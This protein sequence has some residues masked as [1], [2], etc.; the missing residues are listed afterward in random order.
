[1]AW[2]RTVAGRL[3]SDFRYSAGIVYNN[4]PWP[5]PT[6]EQQ[7]HVEEKAR[8]VLAA[9]EPH[10]PPRGMSTLADLYDPLIMPAALVRAHVE[11][12][13]EVEKCYR[14]EAFHSDRERVEFLFRLYEQLT[15]PL[16]PA[17]PR[18]RTVR[19]RVPTPRRSQ[20]ARTPR[21]PSA[22]R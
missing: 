5:S 9:R 19:A 8:V 10:L 18:R 7:A 2:V 3:K 14:A 13:R 1:M 16:L 22:E 12:D 6:P 4:F 11:L 15:A 17:A 20:R 21:L